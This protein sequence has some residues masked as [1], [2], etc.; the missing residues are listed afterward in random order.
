LLAAVLLFGAL[1][2]VPRP[3]AAQLARA[4]SA[5]VLLDA[6]RQF[7]TAGE[8]E[9][10]R[11]IYEMVARRFGDTASATQA[12]AR[13]DGLGRGEIEQS[14]Q[15]ELLVWSSL[16]GAFLGVAVPGAFGA[17]GSEPYGL[18]LL[19]GAPAG[20]IFGRTLGG[21]RG[22]TEGQAR[23][24]TLGG[25]WGAWQ[26]F[27]WREVFDIGEE[28]ICSTFDGQ[29]N[30]YESSDSAEETFAAMILGSLGGVATGT[31]L[32]RQ[33]ISSG[34][35][36]TVNFG[37]L[38]GTWF[39][40]AGGVIAD[41]EGDGLL[42]ATLVAGDAGLLATALLAPGWNISQSRARL[43]SIAGVIGGLA[44][45]GVDLLFQ[46]DDERLA[47][48]I[49]LVGSITGLV[50]GANAT[51]DYDTGRVAVTGEPAPSGALM[52]RK[53]GRWSFGAPLPYPV[54]MFQAGPRGSERG[55]GLGVTVLKAEF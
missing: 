11:A 19:V 45:G 27:G 52:T 12:L 38:W 34:V 23:A 7:E 29:Q 1:L 48:G 5:A 22:L 51:R 26:G 40:L 53:D 10:A 16:Y 31:L 6:A 20:F 28:E 36:S 54:A 39:G 25:T 47:I 43:I 42:T 4:D 41:L 46:P 33:P 49:P 15:V 30:C 17:E 24:I 37:S 18:G 14:G 55:I 9:V 50:I 8:A 2:A 3:G 44:G 13:I 32:S 21:E 35:A